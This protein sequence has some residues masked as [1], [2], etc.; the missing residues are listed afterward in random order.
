VWSDPT[1]LDFPAP[2]F[3]LF[4]P[5]DT[6]VLEGDTLA[7]TTGRAGYLLGTA[8]VHAAWR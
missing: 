5:A 1:R 2:D 8:L 7:V 4:G 3:T 6:I